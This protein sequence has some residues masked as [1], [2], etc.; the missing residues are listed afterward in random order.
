MKEGLGVQSHRAPESQSWLQP[1]SLAPTWTALSPMRI[2]RLVPVCRT[3]L[4][5]A[6][7]TA[8][9][10]NFIVRHQS[11]NEEQRD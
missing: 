5:I 2:H 8:P 4:L 3:P 1:L 6:I 10:E 9:K 11:Q 7:E